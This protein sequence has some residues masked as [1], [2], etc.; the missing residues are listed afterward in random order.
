[1]FSHQRPLNY[2]LRTFYMVIYAYS[3]PIEQLERYGLDRHRAIRFLK[4]HKRR[5]FFKGP[6]IPR[7]FKCSKCKKRFQSQSRF[8]THLH[9]HD[10]KKK[11]H[12]RQCRATFTKFTDYKAHLKTDKHLDTTLPQIEKGG[13]EKASIS[14]MLHERRVFSSHANV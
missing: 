13:R 5:L 7:P 8:Q 1:M 4:R 12:C 2:E 14:Y 9:I 11:L 3:D 6:A 10:M